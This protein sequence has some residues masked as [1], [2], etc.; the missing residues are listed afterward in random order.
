MS[1][2]EHL[3]ENLLSYVQAVGWSEASELVNF[4]DIYERYGSNGNVKV[5]KE[6]FEWLL[7]MAVY[8]VYQESVWDSSFVEN[9]REK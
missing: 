9:I 3:I 5:S 8:V 6:I 1:N 2:E 7:T 4:D